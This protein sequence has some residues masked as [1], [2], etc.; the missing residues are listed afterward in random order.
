M[1][2]VY[3]YSCS[4]LVSLSA[5]G[6]VQTTVQ[7]F[8]GRASFERKCRRSEQMDELGH[9]LSIV[10]SYWESSVEGF[11]CDRYRQGFQHFSRGTNNNHQ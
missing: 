4:C 2:T 3:V 6:V 11:V 5:V 10:I 9:V 1:T 8:V 7:V